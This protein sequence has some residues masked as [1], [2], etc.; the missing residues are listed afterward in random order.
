[1]LNFNLSISLYLALAFAPLLAALVVA[2]V[3][4]VR[5]RRIPNLLALSLIIA[6]L[7][8]FALTSNSLTIT[9][10]IIGLVLG[11]VVGTVLFALRALGGGDVKLLA[12]IGVWTGPTLLLA[13]LALSLVLA[14]LLAIVSAVR[15]GALRNLMAN[16]LAML[17]DMY[18]RR[19]PAL[20]EP[21]AKTWKS[22]GRPLPFAVPLALATLLTILFAGAL[23][24]G[25]A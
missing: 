23:A 15:R 22:S 24:G 17:L 20:A 18:N 21:G 6:G 5:T 3:Y 10:A 14:M 9:Q 25:A 4:D 2:A 16:A 13:V 12:A 1:M 19:S 7:L 8:R 11:F